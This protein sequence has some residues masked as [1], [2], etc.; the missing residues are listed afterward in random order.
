M[1]KAFAMQKPITFFQPKILAISE[2]FRNFIIINYDIVIFE[3]LDQV[4]N[5]SFMRVGVKGKNLYC[6]LTN[7]FFEEWFPVGRRQI[8]GNKSVLPMGSVYTFHVSETF[9]RALDKQ[10]F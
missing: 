10:G 9:Y 1:R 2:N 8:L 4:D 5:S 3:Q 7:S 6:L